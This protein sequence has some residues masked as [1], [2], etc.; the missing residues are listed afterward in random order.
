MQTK[1]KQESRAGRRGGIW[2]ILKYHWVFL[3]FLGLDK[4]I[5]IPPIKY[6][7][8]IASPSN[9]YVETLANQP[10]EYLNSPGEGRVAVWNFGT[11]RSLGFYVLPVPQNTATDVYTTAADKQRLGGVQLFTFAAP[12]SNPGLFLVRFKQL[13]DRGQKPAAIFLEVSPFSF[14]EN[15]RYNAL[16]LQEGVPLSFVLSNLELLP[17]SYAW[18]IIGS[19]IVALSRYKISLKA[20]KRNLGADDS[21]G[22]FGPGSIISP[23]QFEAEL[24]KLRKREDRVYSPSEFKDFHIDHGSPL[25]Q[26]FKVVMFTQVIEQ[27]FFAGWKIDSEQLQLLDSMLSLAQERGVP[28][29]MWRPKVHQQ[30]KGLYKKYAVEEELVPQFRRLADR[31]GAAYVDLNVPGVLQ[32]PYMQDASHVS[33]RC[34]TEMAAVILKHVPVIPPA[35]RVGSPGVKPNAR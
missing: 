4:L 31:H 27:E 34:F 8:T 22:M 23:G 12:G 7:L 5:L 32:C 6:A 16:T 20:A 17:A 29:V 26:Q 11:S 9:P 13:L 3:L 2:V 21:S 15:S 24:A 10:S 1:A 28:V 30:I 35:G 18:Q 14:N 19:R 25:E 33:T